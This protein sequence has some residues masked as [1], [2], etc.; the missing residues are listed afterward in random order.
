MPASAKEMSSETVR[1]PGS[2]PGEFP[3]S[4]FLAEAVEGA[5][6]P[7]VTRAVPRALQAV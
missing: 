5:A 1:A 6:L 2:F 4:A 3:A 7:A